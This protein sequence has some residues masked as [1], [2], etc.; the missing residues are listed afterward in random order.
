[1]IFVGSLRV[2]SGTPRYWILPPTEKPA[3]EPSHQ[4]AELGG[5]AAARAGRRRRA[6]RAAGLGRHRRRRRRARR[7]ARTGPPAAP[8]GTSQT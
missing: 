3:S 6:Q 4:A 1:M 8:C 2:A 7:L 5:G